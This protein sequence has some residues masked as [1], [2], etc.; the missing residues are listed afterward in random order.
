MNKLAKLIADAIGISESIAYN[1]LITI[2]II[3]ALWGLRRATLTIV[4]KRT[5][6]QKARYSWRKGSSYVVYAI[7]VLLLFRTWFEGVDSL[8]TYLGLLSAGIALALKDPI[9]NIAG[10]I[11]IVW[12][13]PF[14]VGDRVQLGKHSGDV[15]DQRIF[16]F[17][18]LEIGNW[19][20]A[21][22]STGR[23]IHIPNGKIF[24]D[25]QANYTKAFTYIWDELPVLV[26]FESDWKKAKQILV[27]ISEEQ[28]DLEEAARQKIRDASRRYLIYY[29]KL[30][31]R[32]YTTVKDS[33]VLLTIRYLCEPR[34][35]RLRNE[36]L[37]E[38]ILDR[39]AEHPDIDLAYPTQ[40]FYRLGEER[41]GGDTPTG[42]GGEKGGGS[43]SRGSDEG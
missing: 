32:V 36:T 29:N 19:V 33:G 3:I 15:I 17:T 8:A 6:D 37:W 42:K 24:T 25:D 12:R 23:I 7:G 18:I 28:D 34:R 41:H 4:N 5:E 38:E 9:V 20:D 16:Q 2:L 27:E 14:E 10:W 22:Q 30:T 1:S 39:F 11:F 13:R 40:R 35:R 21:D 26:T 43:E 31:P